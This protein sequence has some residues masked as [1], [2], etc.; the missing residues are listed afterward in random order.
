[1]Y[2]IIYGCATFVLAPLIHRIRGAS[3]LRRHDLRFDERVKSRI[4]DGFVKSPRSRLAGRESEF[5]RANGKSIK[6]LTAN[7]HVPSLRNE[8]YLRYAAVTKDEA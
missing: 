3:F 7:I 6:I 1:M 8:A 2:Y 5:R 4:P